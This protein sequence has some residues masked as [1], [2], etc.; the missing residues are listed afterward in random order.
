MRDERRPCR[1]ALVLVASALLCGSVLGPAGAAERSV[2]ASE[3][4]IS[5]RVFT[6]AID[7][8][9]RVRLYAVSGDG[10]LTQAG[11][12]SWSNGS[13]YAFAVPD[14]SYK[15]RTEGDSYDG[16]EVEW[17]QDKPTAA[18]APAI[19]VDGE[20]VRLDDVF[21]QRRRAV[22]GRVTG[23]DGQGLLG[24]TVTAY[25]AGDPED[26]Y[27]SAR[28]GPTGA[29]T[30]P[31]GRGRWK[32]LVEDPTERVAPIWVG[33]ASTHGTASIIA[34]EENT[35][36]GTTGAS[37][38]ASIS[39]VVTSTLGTP[40]RSLRVSAYD[41]EGNVV[42]T[43][44]TGFDGGYR[45]S[46]L[47]PGPY[48]V[49][50]GDQFGGGHPF[51]SEH[52]ENATYLA[53]ATPVK[54]TADQHVTGLDAV[55]T[56]HTYGAPASPG[57][58]GRVVDTHGTPAAAL[59]VW[60]ATEDDPGTSGGSYIDATV[61]DADGVYHLSDMTAGETFRIFFDT[62]TPDDARQQLGLAPTWY[63]SS[64]TYAG[65]A[66][67]VATTERLTLPEAVL[68][69]NGGVRG[70][71]LLEDGSSLGDPWAGDPSD[72]PRV[73]AF[74]EAGRVVESTT[75]ESDGSYQLN[76]LPA[77]SYRI[78]FTPG[79]WGDAYPEQWWGGDTF[80]AAT[81]VMVEAGKF[82][83]DIDAIIRTR[84]RS[85]VGRVTD[86]TGAP[87][88]DIPVGAYAPRDTN[89]SYP[90]DWSSTDT[91]GTFELRVLPN[92]YRLRF[93]I[94]HY[95]ERYVTEFYDDR[96]SLA[97][98]EV[99]TVPDGQ[100][101]VSIGPVSLSKRPA[102]SGRLTD[103]RSSPIVKGLVVGY[104]AD[105]SHAFDVQTDVDGRWRSP[106]LVPGSYRLG[107]Y[108]ADHADE[109]Y[110]DVADLASASPVHVAAETHV[111]G[112]DARMTY[113]T[114]HVPD[115][116]GPPEPPGP[117]D[118]VENVTPPRIT[119]TPA[120]GHVLTAEN[121]IWAPGD[122]TYEYQWLSDGK[123]V[124][125]SRSYTVRWSD[126]GRR[127]ELRV[128]GRSQGQSLT[129]RADPV[130]VERLPSRTRVSVATLSRLDERSFRVRIAVRVAGPGEAGPG[131]RL[132]IKI[133]GRLL[134]LAP[135]NG[136][137]FMQR[138]VVVSPGEHMVR[139]I[140]LGS[141]RWLPSRAMERMRNPSSEP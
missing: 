41:A 25:P 107:F 97:E 52:Y 21:I 3:H 39:G 73:R 105:G 140:F 4:V 74:D 99:V 64:R 102:M 113:G 116:S 28:T 23:P 65:A 88:A 112:L 31:T 109:F 84:L 10:S 134:V 43:A 53:Q 46:A 135:L 122:V 45:L 69:D 141:L 11:V 106:G 32:L 75:V 100:P 44:M 19:E 60:A 42:D 103:Q 126:V 51:T 80:V 82:S 123:E 131:A 114:S 27:T 115:S 89:E 78:Q 138:T 56:A 111:T 14:G 26:P 30:L 2:A 47:A 68:P 118:P 20:D 127:I 104:R 13:Y 101:P 117:T 108:G 5:F 36:V 77:G 12:Q 18:E 38:G 61:T 9:S 66:V 7:E 86:T 55:L 125:R 81:P 96:Q 29:F 33:G 90:T 70:T 16:S 137:G 50:F 57:V 95:E 24:A 62:Y 119:G 132:K 48:R 93:G 76:E 67:I 94:A 129:V 136:R 121:G 58:T 34:V 124:G 59:R 87:V 37:S 120:Q 54:V 1:P 83:D 79:E 110:A 63:P 22:S 85:L 92:D 98:A 15:I 91:D 17:Y 8:P 139:A 133:D 71:A 35:T 72:Q 40:I 49:R 6:P 130:E 128:T